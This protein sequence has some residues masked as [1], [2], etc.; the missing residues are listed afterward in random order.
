MKYSG[1]G[2]NEVEPCD[3]LYITEDSGWGQLGFGAVKKIFP[4]ASA[5]FWSPG[6]SKPDLEN[7]HGDWILSF[8]S[9]LI[10]PLSVIESAKKGAVNFHPAPPH[11]RG[12]G[13]YWWA[14]KNRDENFG[15]TCH[16]MNEHI[17][18]GKIIQVN[19]FAV[20]HDDTM[21]SLREKAAYFSLNLL[22]SV[23]DDIYMKKPLTPC[24][25]EW[26]G[27]LYTQKELDKILEQDR[28][29]SAQNINDSVRLLKSGS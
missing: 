6:M 10:L 9:D 4:K 26:T 20:D 29:S 21:E 5:I 27:R 17:D 16:H 12:I 15:V 14:L 18:H 3:V 7:W 13:G 2:E 11:Y 8:K 22:K 19:H 24:G 1:I 28:K 25:L 23:L